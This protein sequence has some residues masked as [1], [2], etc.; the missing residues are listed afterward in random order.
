MYGD[1]L[2]RTRLV[3]SWKGWRLLS[4]R[5]SPMWA[6]LRKPSSAWACMLHRLW[7]RVRE[8]FVGEFQRTRELKQVMNGCMRS[9]PG[10]HAL[11]KPPTKQV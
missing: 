7:E 8:F 11:Q 3:P 4:A 1:S 6:R 9:E 10:G 2:R 5:D